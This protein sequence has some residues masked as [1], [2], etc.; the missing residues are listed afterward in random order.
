MAKKDYNQKITGFS[1][2]PINIAKYA[3]RHYTKADIQIRLVLTFH[4]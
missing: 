4:L 2:R 1:L 3:T